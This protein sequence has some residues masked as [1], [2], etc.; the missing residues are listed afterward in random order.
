M[1]SF[2]RG[3]QLDHLLCSTSSGGGSAPGHVSFVQPVAGGTLVDW[4]QVLYNHPDPKLSLPSFQHSPS[5]KMLPRLLLTRTY[6]RFERN[7]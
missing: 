5:K 6:L 3:D 1:F 4:G 7:E 2:G